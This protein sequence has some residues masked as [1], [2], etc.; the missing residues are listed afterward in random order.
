MTYVSAGLVEDTTLV[1]WSAQTTTISLGSCKLAAASKS[2]WVV[3]CCKCVVSA[4]P[5]IGLNLKEVH[6]AKRAARAWVICCQCLGCWGL[7]LPGLI[8]IIVE[9]RKKMWRKRGKDSDFQARWSPWCELGV[10]FYCG[11]LCAECFICRG[12]LQPEALV[13]DAA[14]SFCYV[15]VPGVVLCDGQPGCIKGSADSLGHWSKT[16]ITQ[17]LFWR[18]LIF[19][20]NHITISHPGKL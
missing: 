19:F 7:V 9:E 18:Q 14:A 13:A 8:Q 5:S 6:R 3:S 11:L 2:V 1:L 4:S 10:Y 15:P 16:F 12:W 20:P 17:Q